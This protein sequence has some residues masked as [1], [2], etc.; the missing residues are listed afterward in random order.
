MLA[1]SPKRRYQISGETWVAV[2]IALLG[3][4][5]VSTYLSMRYTARKEH[6]ESEQRTRRESGS[7]ATS[8]AAQVFAATKSLVDAQ[9]DEL[10]ELRVR[11][12]GLED[13]LD[14]TEERAR[15]CE[16]REANLVSQ[17]RAK[18]IDVE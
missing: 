7:V 14:K 10:K 11:V 16:R 8:D 2:I 1:G 9:A 13:R 12:R 3:S 6:K 15:E 5:G 17:L 18:G 4:G